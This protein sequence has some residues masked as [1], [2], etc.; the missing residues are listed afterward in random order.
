M[1]FAPIGEYGKHYKKQALGILWH[2]EINGRKDEDILSAYYNL[3]FSYQFRDSK[4]F[5]IWVNNCGGQNKCW[6]YTM[7]VQVV[8]TMHIEKVTLKYFTVGHT[9]MSVDNFHRSLEK[10]MKQMEKVHDFNDF[11]SNVGEAFVMNPSNFYLFEKVD[12]V[13]AK[14]QRKQDLNSPTFKC[15][16]LGEAQLTCFLSTV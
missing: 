12:L 9:F 6:T 13:K 1:T 15:L 10:E 11:I 3:F 4:N 16:N 2:E 14:F 8:N 5:L 7:V